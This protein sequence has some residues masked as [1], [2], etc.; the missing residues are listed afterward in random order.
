MAF[1]ES[2]HKNSILQLVYTTE[3]YKSDICGF[4]LPHWMSNFWAENLG[5]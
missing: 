5:G 4:V 1:I 3:I 2:G